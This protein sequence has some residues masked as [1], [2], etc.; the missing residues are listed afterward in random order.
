MYCVIEIFNTL[1]KKSHKKQAAIF[2]V[3][4]Y[5][6][7]G[8]PIEL[9]V[10]NVGNRGASLMKTINS[11][12]GHST[13]SKE[14]FCDIEMACVN[15]MTDIFTRAQNTDKEIMKALQEWRLNQNKIKSDFVGAEK[16]L[17]SIESSGKNNIIDLSLNGHPSTFHT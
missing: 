7:E 8:S 4:T 3:K 10:D 16:G 1:S 2:I 5:L 9:N 15:N 12:E 6:T 11:T 17:S 14:L 13:L